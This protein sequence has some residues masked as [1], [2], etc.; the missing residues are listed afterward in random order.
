MFG[1]AAFFFKPHL[2][3]GPRNWSAGRYTSQLDGDS[4]PNTATTL[5]TAF[6]DQLSISRIRTVLRIKNP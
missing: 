3:E 4:N 1:I 6:T 2:L 5:V